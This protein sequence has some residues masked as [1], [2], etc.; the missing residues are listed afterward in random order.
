[1]FITYSKTFYIRL[2]H[3][4]W[5]RQRGSQIGAPTIC[6]NATYLQLLP[7]APCSL[8]SLF[9]QATYL[10]RRFAPCFDIRPSAYFTPLVV[11]AHPLL[12]YR[13]TL[14]VVLAPQ[15]EGTIAMTIIL[16]MC[17]YPHANKLLHHIEKCAGTP[18]IS[19]C[20][21]ILKN[22]PFQTKP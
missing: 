21:I 16:K 14:S 10:L 12:D 5:M 11:G 13:F 4:K 3:Q 22:I 1:M 9:P 19:N 8:H 15:N 17:W 7:R 6:K 2:Y 18:M 20:S